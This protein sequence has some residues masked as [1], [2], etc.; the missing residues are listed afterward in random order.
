LRLFQKAERRETGVREILF[1]WSYVD[2][3]GETGET[4]GGQ[5]GIMK[6]NM[7]LTPVF[8][9]AVIIIAGEKQAGEHLID[10]IF[11][12]VASFFNFNRLSLVVEPVKNG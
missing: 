6:N 5:T 7:S 11:H 12:S 9:G 3:T 8:P 10:R 4:Q 1:R 2:P